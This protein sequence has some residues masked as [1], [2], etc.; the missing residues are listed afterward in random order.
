MPTRRHIL[1]ATAGTLLLGTSTA[2][3]S[4]ALEP[5]RL[6]VTRYALRPAAWPAGLKLR[7]AVLTDL[8]GQEPHMGLDRLA[9]VVDVTNGLG[10]DLICLLGDYAENAVQRGP[11]L[12]WHQVL[13]QLTS[14]K[15][16]LGVHGILGNHEWWDDRDNR[17][18]RGRETVAHRAFR[19]LGLPLY[20]NR[21]V[22][23]VKD[24]APFW[25]AGLGDQLAYPLG[26]RRFQGVDDVP[27]TLAQVTDNAP[28]ILMAHEP[29]IFATLS[30]RVTLTL[31]GHTHGGQV[32]LFGWSPVVPSQFGN[33]YAYGHV[34]ENGRH[35]V[36]SGGLGTVAAGLVPVRFGVP[37]EIVVIDLG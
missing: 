2:G 6:A 16:P 33:R 21:A 20:E 8:H 28:L 13:K 3:Y 37:P 34:V 10:C 30:P 31:S 9:Q 19:D 29:D 36:V 7:I 32:R 26:R 1:G 35:L 11:H 14:L 12:S 5:R 27:G 4:F 18:A 22:R 17:R 23:L 15:A 24:G 25:L